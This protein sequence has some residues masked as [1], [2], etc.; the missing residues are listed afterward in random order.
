MYC[1][2]VIGD[3]D[4]KLFYFFKYFFTYSGYVF[5]SSSSDDDDE[6]SFCPWSSGGVLFRIEVYV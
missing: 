2:F 6:P 1:L 4:F 3:I 5:G